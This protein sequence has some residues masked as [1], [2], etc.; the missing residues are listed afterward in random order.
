MGIYVEDNGTEK[1]YA[2]T[3]AAKAWAKSR[4]QKIKEVTAQTVTQDC[5]NDDPGRQDSDQQHHIDQEDVFPNDEGFNKLLENLSEESQDSEEE[6][7]DQ[8]GSQNIEDEIDEELPEL[9]EVKGSEEY[10]T[11]DKTLISQHTSPA[12]VPEGVNKREEN[13][14]VNKREENEGVNK[15][16]EKE[17]VNREGFSDALKIK[18]PLEPDD[19]QGSKVSI[20]DKV[21]KDFEGNNSPALHDNSPA[22]H[23][24]SPALHDNSPALHDNSPALHDNSP[25]LHDNCSQISKS[26]N[27][28]EDNC[29]TCSSNC[30]HKRDDDQLLYKSCL[31]FLK[32]HSKM[33][34]DVDSG[35][36]KANDT[37]DLLGEIWDLTEVMH[38]PASPELYSDSDGQ[39]YVRQLVSDHNTQ[40][41][42]D[43][44][45][46][47]IL[48]NMEFETDN[49]QSVYR[50]HN[51][52]ALNTSQ[53]TPDDSEPDDDFNDEVD[54]LIS[55][56]DVRN[57]DDLNGAVRDIIGVNS[58][59]V[60]VSPTP[61]P[62]FGE[63]WVEEVRRQIIEEAD[64]QD[65]VEC[66]TNTSEEDESVD[67]L[68]VETPE[69]SSLVE[70]DSSLAD[71]EDLME[72]DSHESVFEEES[73]SHESVFEEE[74]VSHESVFEEE[75]VS[76]ISP[77]FNKGPE[78]D[79]LLRYG[80][81]VAPPPLF[82]Q[83]DGDTS[84]VTPGFKEDLETSSSCSSL[85]P[86][87]LHDSWTHEDNIVIQPSSE[88]DS[89]FPTTTSSHISRLVGGTTVVSGLSI[90][91]QPTESCS[92]E[93]SQPTEPDCH[94]AAEASNLRAFESQL[95]V[96]D[97]QRT[98]K[99][100]QTT[101]KDNT[102]YHRDDLQPR[103]VRECP[104]PLAAD[105]GTKRGVSDVRRVTR[106]METLAGGD[107]TSG[108][109]SSRRQDSIFST[110]DAL[111]SSHEAFVRGRN[112]GSL[113]I[114]R[115]EDDVRAQVNPQVVVPSV[116]RPFQVCGRRGRRPLVVEIE[117]EE[118]V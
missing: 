61:A 98:A 109:T 108:T 1:V 17:G 70:D 110:R 2:L 78:A 13:E 65:E 100:S 42:N 14:G 52:L 41:Q 40:P 71:E 48:E 67:D 84:D 57:T 93:D 7:E 28:T 103:D 92:C 33:P 25:A 75:S 81:P 89:Y 66:I 105:V 19:S 50:R 107:W 56:R 87:S 68:N 58:R 60:R 59:E 23:D 91:P 99:D 39:A 26:E 86:S 45:I 54:E 10:K 35:G 102:H 31:N 79:G 38:T 73:V 21:Q 69:E 85:S 114:I 77:V 32:S 104:T 46:E 34:Q 118:D 18:L 30:P 12:E 62:L 97:S 4:V 11:T 36:G 115:E 112:I 117:E 24:N 63:R 3:P 27:E 43:S 90:T 111:R 82:T 37:K 88:N 6:L 51:L 22:L 116:S 106:D 9:E 49:L 5:D 72:D 44:D 20:D 53:E 29:S 94:L 101:A 80:V 96:K 74:S 47:E 8:R 76:S 55:N 16:E 113:L 15:R 83:A 64:W 95:T